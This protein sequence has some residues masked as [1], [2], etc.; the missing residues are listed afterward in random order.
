MLGG[1]SAQLGLVGNMGGPGD[2]VQMEFYLGG[3][4]GNIFGGPVRREFRA[5]E[6]ACTCALLEEE[7]M[8]IVARSCTSE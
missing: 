8:Y 2:L 1:I 5:W 7:K 6:L 4:L 3:H